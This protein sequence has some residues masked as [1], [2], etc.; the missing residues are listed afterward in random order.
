MVHFQEIKAIFVTTSKFKLDEINGNMRCDLMCEL[1]L[2]DIQVE[3]K[4]HI[5]CVGLVGQN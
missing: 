1:R 4:T 3:D 2:G 5:G